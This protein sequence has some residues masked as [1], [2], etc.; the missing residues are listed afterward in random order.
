MSPAAQSMHAAPRRN[1]QHK[2]QQDGFE[3]NEQNLILVADTV[4]PLDHEVANAAR[5]RGHVVRQLCPSLVR[6]DARDGLEEASSKILSAN[7]LDGIDELV[8]P[9]IGGLNRSLPRR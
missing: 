1:C 9:Q 5:R 2:P 8:D 3:S 4:P 7:V 6:V